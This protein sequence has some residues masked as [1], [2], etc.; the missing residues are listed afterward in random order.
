[1]ELRE[2]FQTLRKRWWLILLCALCAGM[3]GFVASTLMEP[4]YQANVKL[5][6]S[7]NTGVV[8]YS[9]L[10]SGQQILATYRELLRTEPILQTA[11]DN[12]GLPDTPRELENRVEVIAVPETQ[13]L[14]VRV[15]DHNPN[16]AASIANEIAVIFLVQRSEQGLVL[17]VE[18]YEQSLV[19]QMESLEEA[20]A[21]SD[22]DIAELEGASGEPPREQLAALRSEQSRQ[23]AD[24]ANLLSAYL[25]VRTMKSRLLGLVIAEP[26]QPPTEPIRPRK[27]MNTAVATASGGLIGLVLV[28]GLE[29]LNDALESTEDV[30]Q[31]LSLPNLGSI[32]VVNSWRK[33]G[34]SRVAA[35]H[36]AAEAFRVLRTN[37]RFA[38]AGVD[39]PVRSLMFTSAAPAEGKTSIVAN[40]G[41]VTAQA[42]RQVLLVDADLR[43]PRLHD[44]FGVPGQVGLA[45]LL[46]DDADPENGIV[47][48]GVD[49]LRL[50]PA[51]TSP[52]NPSEIL[53]SQRMRRLIDELSDMADVVLFDAPPTLAG[54][55]AMVLAAE[56]DGVIVVVDSHSTRREAAKQ[57][58]EMLQ[59]ADATVLGTVLNKARTG[60]IEYY[61][62]GNGQ[63]REPLRQ[64]WAD[65]LEWAQSS[66]TTVQWLRRRLTDLRRLASL[67]EQQDES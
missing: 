1:M 5:M 59:N 33:N 37:V 62:S 35:T 15:R 6:S 65:L 13:L 40:L 46:I 48:T 57:A 7:S 12:L 36:P 11:I 27:A 23:R 22:A 52:P 19:R 8:D 54:A 61:Y 44:V 20:I 10:M 16:R 2:V 60:T 14:E 32:P 43:H 56:V 66:G 47:D 50:M 9:S 49:N 18:E 42:G 53:G 24:Y 28:F 31:A 25:D 45:S 4:V 41:I 64:R 58:L 55:D 17:E 29:Y 26:A 34:V 67:R 38:S 30:R 63:E 21:Q 51:G 3:A 39:I